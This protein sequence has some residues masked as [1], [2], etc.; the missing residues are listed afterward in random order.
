MLSRAEA[1]QSDVISALFA[2]GSLE[3]AE[4][5]QRCQE[6]RMSRRGGEA[7]RGWPWRCRSA[8]CWACRRAICQRWWQGVTLWPS[9]AD[10]SV[11]LV[12]LPFVYQ[13]GR[14]RPAVRYHRRACRDL[15]DRRARQS[16]RW[17]LVAMAGMVFDD[18]T[19]LLVARHAGINRREIAQAF[20]SRWPDASVGKIGTMPA[21][22]EFDLD[23][24]VELA[25]V[26]RGVEPLRIVVLPQR[27]VHA[28][29][30]SERNVRTG[31]LEPMPFLF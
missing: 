19:M 4:R 8:G 17:R 14:L 12:H 30:Q 3:V 24:A 16:H 13:P 10:P 15:R 2:A 20:Q 25:R 27:G 11:S 7:V 23:D 5:L 29:V 21:S 28:G 1:L 22:W 31:G 9:D 26:R 6:E 18:R